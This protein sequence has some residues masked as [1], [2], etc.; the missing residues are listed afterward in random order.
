MLAVRSDTHSLAFRCFVAPQDTL[1]QR[2]RAPKGR[3][4]D[5]SKRKTKKRG[6][7]QMKKSTKGPHI[8]ATARDTI[9]VSIVLNW[10]K[11]SAFENVNRWLKGRP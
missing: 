7:N 4:R 5:R 11:D 3:R 10:L 1:A 6:E 2:K 8:K 9:A